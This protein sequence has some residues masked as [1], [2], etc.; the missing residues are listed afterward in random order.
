MGKCFSKN[1]NTVDILRSAKREDYQDFSFNGFVRICKVVSVYDGDTVRIVFFL[2]DPPKMN[3][4]PI[5][6]S[7]RLYGIDTPEIRTKDPIEKKNGYNAKQRLIELIG[8]DLIK[9][10]FGKDDKYG[11]PLATLAHLNDSFENSI[12]NKLVVENYA[13]P[14]FGGK[15]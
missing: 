3:E 2:N 13:K 5:M 15:K 10:S 9:V 1:K 8:N 11:R 6:C 4:T 7:V 12:N 14:Y